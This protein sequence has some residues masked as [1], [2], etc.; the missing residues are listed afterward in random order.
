M[1]QWPE[2][3]TDAVFKRAMALQLLS[4]PLGSKG[5]DGT[6]YSMNFGDVLHSTVAK[7]FQ[8]VAGAKCKAAK[9]VIQKDSAFVVKVS[10]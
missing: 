1:Q 3:N 8:Q 2:H 4:F 9:A 7:T 5:S 6:P 10:F